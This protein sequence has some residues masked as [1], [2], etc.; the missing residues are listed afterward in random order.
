MDESTMCKNLVEATLNSDFG[1]I[2]ASIRQ[3]TDP[4][5]R[6]A[7][8]YSPLHIAVIHGNTRSANALLQHGANPDL[9][10][11]D[12]RS[13]LSE[14]IAQNDETMIRSLA[15]YGADIR[16]KPN[17]RHSYLDEAYLGRIGPRCKAA[18][19]LQ[20]LGLSILDSSLAASSTAV[21]HWIVWE[22]PA[23]VAVWK[24]DDNTLKRCL[25]EGVDPNISADEPILFRAIHHGDLTSFRLLIA[26]GADVNKTDEANSTALM[27]ACR[28][29]HI[30]IVQELISLG[31]DV[32]RAKKSGQTALHITAKSGTRTSPEVVKLLIDMNANVNQADRFGY[33]PLMEATKVQNLDMIR[34]LIGAGADKNAVASTGERAI[35]LLP[36]DAPEELRTLLAKTQMRSNIEEI[37]SD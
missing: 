9:L 37:S 21:R 5:C 1:Q 33:T 30:Q 29:G 2:Q 32:N 27:I 19:T 22:A 26:K 10:L 7:E 20:D 36:R 11:P 25:D 24:G 18:V 14:A 34:L 17:G 13:P 4:N 15:K 16:R 31:A 3:G 8:G 12:G 23:I 6:D 28:H 35:N